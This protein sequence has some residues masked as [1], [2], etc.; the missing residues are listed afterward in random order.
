VFRHLHVAVIVAA[1]ASAPIGCGRAF[2]PAP[3]GTDPGADA[4]VNKPVSAT[5]QHDGVIVTVS[6]SAGRVNAGEPI[7]VRVDVLNAGLGEVSWQS[8]GCELLN[9]FA[10]DGPELE[11]PPEGRA[12]PDAAGLAK[13]SA[14]TGGVALEWVRSPDL[15]DG[16]AFACPADLRYEDI[17]PGETITADAVW[18]GRTSDG[19]PAPPGAYRVMYAF[20]F[21]GR[22]PADQLPLEPPAPQPIEVAV[23]IVL[24]GPAFKGIPSTTAVDAALGDPRVT[25]WISDHL[26]KQR[27]TGAEIR[28]VDDRWRFTIKVDGDRA[29]VIFVDPATGTVDEVQLAD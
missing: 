26:T 2:G 27:L 12:W 28:L 3:A 23:P 18:S 17:A 11:Q 7:H 21:M 15:P 4:P 5:A 25:R 22:M 19:V 20:P 10:I 6:A 13:W 24:D 29:T 1:L 16:V 8:G 9:G 14:T